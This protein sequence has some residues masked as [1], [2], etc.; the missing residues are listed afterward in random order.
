MKYLG[1]FII[2][3]TVCFVAE[4]ISA[5]LPYPI[6]ASIYGLGL[7]LVLLFSRAIKVSAVRDVAAFFIE[8]MPVMF[9][10][11]AVGL[12]TAKDVI[13]SNLIGIVIVVS[14]VAIIVL[15]V[16]ALVTQ[17]LYEY[18]ISRLKRKYEKGQ[19]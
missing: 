12:I 14:I 17:K 19:K 9:I 1:Q 3:L 6:P 10:P 13:L 7:M 11:A 2:I 18:K 8:I 15:A 5:L 4:L 16:S